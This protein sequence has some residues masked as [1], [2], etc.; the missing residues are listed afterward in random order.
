MT[1]PDEPLAPLVLSYRF[2]L[3]PDRKLDF[4]IRLNGES[5]AYE[6]G[7]EAGE[8]PVGEPFPCSDCPI[9]E[10]GL[11]GC[12]VL[13]SIKPYLDPFQGMAS[14]D[15]VDVTIESRER[16]I[17]HKEAS[18]QR[19]L[20]SMIGILMVSSGCPD[21]DKLRPMVRLHL[22]LA[23]VE[24]TL[25]RAVS[26][27][28]FAQ[29]MRSTHG[30]DPD[31]ELAGLVA[32]YRRIEVINQSLS[33]W[34]RTDAESDTGTNAIVLLDVFAKMLPVAMERQFAEFETLF[35]PYLGDEG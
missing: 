18:L 22:P 17:T 8:P 16:F 29:Y 14:F 33:H 20:S 19:A 10:S 32:I 31:W 28:L 13:A 30:L 35:K 12:P 5:L 25:F 4:E 6:G 2:Q 26:T 34:M 9:S 7:A 21:L 15:R 11:P 23:S 27:Y 1:Q 3:Q 24:E